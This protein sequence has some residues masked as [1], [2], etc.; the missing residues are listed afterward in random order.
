MITTAATGF[1]VLSCAALE[2]L[3]AAWRALVDDDHDALVVRSSSTVEDSTSSSMAG[4]FASVLGVRGWDELLTAIDTVLASAAVPDDAA[5][6]ARPMA[7]LVQ[8]QLDALSGGVLFGF[9][10]VD[11]DPGHVVVEV[12]DGSPDAARERGRRG[13]AL[14]ARPV[15]PTHPR[16]GSDPTA[17]VAVG[18]SPR[19]RQAGPASR[20]RVQRAT[21]RRM[22]GGHDRPAVA[23]AEPPGDGLRGCSLGYRPDPRSWARGRDLSGPLRPLEVDLWVDPLRRGIVGA[24]RAT[25]AV[26][27]RRMARSPVVTTI[28]G[29]PAADLELLGIQQ[30]R[31]GV[32]S[33]VNPVPAARH[34]GA[35]WRVGRLRAALP[36]LVADLLASVDDDLTSIGDLDALDDASLL[37][38]LERSRGELISLHADEVLAGMLL[39]DDR[40]PSLGSVALDALRTGRAAGMTDAELAATPA[41]LA[42]SPPLSAGRPNCRML[43]PGHVSRRSVGELGPRGRSG[44][45][46]GG[47]RSSV[48]GWHGSSVRVSPTPAPCQKRRR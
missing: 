18:S 7:V 14:R 46:A 25:G 21:G 5:S 9:D 44:C 34:L 8:P 22:G 17:A 16:L 43:P 6:D 32:W 11:G 3:H 42:S 23:A 1:G 2:P 33:I 47:C 48:A 20:R 37:D 28:G 26:A 45:G 30:G 10:P 19:P 24:L 39:L 35:A 41:V 12:V 36:A 40:G 4:R 38:L 29:R 15:R 27:P 13:S 31:G